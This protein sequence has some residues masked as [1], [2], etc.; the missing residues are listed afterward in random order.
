MVGARRSPGTPEASSGVLRALLRFTQAYDPL[1]LVDRP[2]LARDLMV[3]RH[4]LRM[5]PV[6]RSSLSWWIT[7]WTRVSGV[8]REMFTDTD[9]DGTAVEL[10]VSNAGPEP[11]RVVEA[12]YP[13]VVELQGFRHARS[14]VGQQDEA[15]HG[16]VHLG[17][18]RSPASEPGRETREGPVGWRDRRIASGSSVDHFRSRRRRRGCHPPG[19]RPRVPAR[20][21][22]GHTTRSPTGWRVLQDTGVP[23][24]VEAELEH[25]RRLER[26]ALE[27]RLPMVSLFAA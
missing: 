6:R 12:Q 16:R 19:P 7:T 25:M 2:D 20:G 1:V 4:G 5:L 18:I 22:S 17:D 23:G 8:V 3:D 24:A 9:T 14:S 21:R 27:D 10:R 13:R 15:H 26:A 11:A